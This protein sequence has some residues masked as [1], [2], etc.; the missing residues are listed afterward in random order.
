MMWSL[1]GLSDPSLFEVR[2]LNSLYLGDLLTMMIE[3]FS[4]VLIMKFKIGTHVVWFVK[5]FTWSNVLP[6]LTSIGKWQ[7]ES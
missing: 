5:N 7:L 6:M 3:G 2:S 1:G 4:P